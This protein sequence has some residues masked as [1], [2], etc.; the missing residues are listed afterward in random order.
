[1]SASK[2]TLVYLWDAHVHDWMPL[3]KRIGIDMSCADKLASKSNTFQFMLK[4]VK[5]PAANIIK[6]EALSKDG[7]AVVSR[8]TIVDP[9]SSTDILLSFTQK[10]ALAFCEGIAEQPFGLKAIAEAIKT[11]INNVQTPVEPWVING[12]TLFSADKAGIMG[13]INVTPDSFSDGGQMDSEASILS[14]A[15]AMLQSGVAVLDVGG[16]STRPGSEAVAPSIQCERVLP[17]IQSILKRFPSAVLSID[18]TSAEVASQALE[19]G[20]M[21]VND[22]S[23]GQFDNKMFEV[24]ARHKA[25]YILMHTPSL[26]KEMQQ[27]CAYDDFWESLW[28]YFQEQT[29]NAVSHRI[30]KNHIMIDPGLG[31]GKL[32]AHN[33]SIMAWM[34]RLRGLGF[35]VLVGP[36]R[37]RFLGELAGIDN[38]AMRDW[39]TAAAVSL[40]VWNGANLIRVHQA[41]NLTQV[42]SVV[43]TILKEKYHA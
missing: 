13:I 19:A 6:Q 34:K 8:A 16:E 11:I 38:P 29:T 32:L 4:H 26:P 17:A 41:E 39:A 27:H 42:T 21:I 33:L 1:M 22:I 20:A 36:S 14:R 3:W 28:G 23:G 5:A 31:F 30:P 9:K 43:N 37:K 15:E 35:P 24:V 18:T 10:Q 2:Q 25:Y 7:E 40:N 12:Q